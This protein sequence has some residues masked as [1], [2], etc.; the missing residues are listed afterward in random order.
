MSWN[1]KNLTASI[2]ACLS[3]AALISGCDFGTAPHGSGASLLI[4]TGFGTHVIGTVNEKSVGS[5]ETAL[6]QLEAHFKVTTGPSGDRVVAI[7]GVRARKGYTWSLFIDG[8]APT[9]FP[10]KSGLSSGEKV[11]WDL[12][13]TAAAATVEAVVGSFPQPFITGDSGQEFP[14]LINCASQSTATCDR[15]QKVLEKLGVKASEQAFGAGS[16]DD[17]LSVVIGPF[18]LQRG[19]IAA[20]LLQAGPASSGVYARFVGPGGSVLELLNAAGQVEQ[21]LRGNVGLIS[22]TQQANLTA[23]VW[24]I[25]GTDEAGV[26]LAGRAFGAK[27]LADHY[28]VA[29]TSSGIIPLPV[30]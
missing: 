13:P 26:A 25:T 10:G 19:I 21:T 16:G 6:S 4:T 22:A 1:S 9:G 14:T 7:N 27:P 30:R 5:D 12:R 2:A 17:S 23:P 18:S 3:V 20:E 8:V 24:L 11:W 15:V 28:A 29:V